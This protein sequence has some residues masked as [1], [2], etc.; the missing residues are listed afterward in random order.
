MLE[1]VVRVVAKLN[2]DLAV[3]FREPAEPVFFAGEAGDLE[4]IAGNILDNAAK[5]AK[6]QVQVA[7]LPA[8]G[9]DGSGARFELV[10]ED[11]GPGIPEEQSREVLKR[12]KRLDE[13][14]P[15]SGLGLSIVAELVREYGGEIALDRS[16]LGGLRATVRLSAVD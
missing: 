7:V 9:P 4:E 13:S 15:G 8:A 2:P 3:A 10:I 12:G 5:W 14:K 6:A 16:P 1:R 11:D